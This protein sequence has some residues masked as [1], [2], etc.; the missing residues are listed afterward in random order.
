MGLHSNASHAVK[1]YYFLFLTP[2]QS[3]YVVGL[4]PAH[5]RAIL[6]NTRGETHKLALYALLGFASS[7]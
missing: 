1:V 6:P 5:M 4:K 3:T 2:I 7:V